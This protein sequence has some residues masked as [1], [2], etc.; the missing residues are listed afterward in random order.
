MA[1]LSECRLYLISPPKLS[2]ANFLGPL[3]SGILIDTI[4]NQRVFWVL[5]LLVALPIPLL[6][7]KPRIWPPVAKSGSADGEGEASKSVFD[8]WRIPAL[9]AMRATNCVQ[10]RSPEG[11]RIAG[12]APCSLAARARTEGSVSTASA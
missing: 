7:L 11:S 4:G 3:M 2:A 6:W 9:R 8:L 5:A 12:L 10:S 1:P